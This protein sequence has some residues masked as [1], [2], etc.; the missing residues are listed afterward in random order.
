MRLRRSWPP[1][2]RWRCWFRTAAV[3][4]LLLAVCRC[5]TA[6]CAGANSARNAPLPHATQA[7]LAASGT[8]AL[9]GRDDEVRVLRIEVAE[10]QRSA[11]VARRL[12]PRIPL[13]DQDVARLQADLLAARREAE[14]L[15]LALENPDNQT[16]R[17]AHL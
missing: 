8:L 2:A 3:H 15:S 12:L 6:G 17:A 14:A 11:D 5:S 13:L 1:L 16:R 7:E 10:L 9:L 4:H